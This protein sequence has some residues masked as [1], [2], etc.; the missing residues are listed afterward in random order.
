MET[1]DERTW[2]E[3][4][5]SLKFEAGKKKDEAI[6]WIKEHKEFCYAVIPVLVTGLLDIGKEV[7]RHGRLKEEKRLKENYI[8]DRSKGHYVEARRPL[9]PKE[10]RRFDELRE[11]GMSSSDILR[12]LR[13]DK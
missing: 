7:S 4:I 13:L 8:Y 9:K 11:Q 6:S 2:K 1:I 12:E 10:W 3:K 5:E